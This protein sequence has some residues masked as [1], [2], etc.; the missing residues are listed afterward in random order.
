MGPIG[1]MGVMGAETEGTEAQRF[2]SI[3]QSKPDVQAA[4]PANER[5]QFGFYTSYPVCPPALA[6]FWAARGHTSCHDY[7]GL[8]DEEKCQPNVPSSKCSNQAGHGCTD[9]SNNC[10]QPLHATGCF[11]CAF[12][13]GDV[14]WLWSNWTVHTGLWPNDPGSATENIWSFAPGTVS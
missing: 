7:K 13:L 11:E 5:R 4:P 2:D 12:Y 3:S 10:G 8:D 1:I 6:T 14:C 9:Q